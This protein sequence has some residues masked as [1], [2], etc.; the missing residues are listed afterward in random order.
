M[1]YSKLHFDRRQIKSFPI[2]PRLRN[3]LHSRFD[4]V[5]F[6]AILFVLLRSR[7][8]WTNLVCLASIVFGVGPIVFSSLLPSLGRE[9]SFL[10]LVCIRANYVTLLRSCI[11]FYQV[12]SFSFD[13][14]RP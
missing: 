4:P 5:K 6:R 7:K 11:D 9:L 14:I 13:T 3:S 10:D 2:D 8:L 12:C 1:C